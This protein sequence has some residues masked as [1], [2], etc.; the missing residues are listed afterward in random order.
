MPTGRDSP[1][2]APRTGEV[3]EDSLLDDAERALD[4][5]LAVH[6]GLIKWASFKPGVERLL[7]D[8]ATALGHTAGALWLPR[9][10]ALVARGFWSARSVDRP[11]LEQ[12]LCPLRF[13]R[14]QGL[15]GHVWMRAEPV[16]LGFA[17]GHGALARPV[18]GARRATLGLPA[19]A[20]GEVLGV[21]EL[22]SQSPSPLGARATGVLGMVAH[23]LGRF[24]DRRR[25]ELDM[26]PLTARE[27]DVLTLAARG[28]PVARIGEQL[29]IS[30]G[31]V[32]S[33]LEHIYSKL[34]V[35]N[36]TAAVAGALR[37]G[38]IE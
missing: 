20:D 38:L 37:S 5:L 6:D 17:D 35:V 18:A 21:V 8:L 12:A 26:S 32:K 28:L 19:L 11:L 25:A 3:P 24:F 30:R 14:G 7:G 27:V 2:P 15:P 16:Q 34:G 9:G 31:T 22:Y 36:R 33:H 13:E 1:R 4:V 23:E 10:D 29:E